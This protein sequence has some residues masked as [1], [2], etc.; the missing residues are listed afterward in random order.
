MNT[1]KQNWDGEKEEMEKN[2]SYLPG[3]HVFWVT[4]VLSNSFQ[5]QGLQPIRLLWPLISQTRTVEWVIWHPRDL[6]DPEITAASPAL[7][8]G[9]FSTRTT[10]KTPQLVPFY[11]FNLRICWRNTCS[12]KC[13][14]IKASPGCGLCNRWPG[15]LAEDG[16]VSGNGSKNYVESAKEEKIISVS[17]LLLFFNCKMC[18]GGWGRQYVFWKDK[19]TDAEICKKAE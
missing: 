5:S 12:K 17:K 8:G 9:L 1:V 13:S 16:S 7:A 10:W 11:A 19:E 6:A 15:K 4:S 18:V 14:I 2:F 3:M